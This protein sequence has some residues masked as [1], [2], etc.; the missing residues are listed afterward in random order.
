MTRHRIN[1]TLRVVYRSLG[2][3]LAIA[4]AAKLLTHVPGFAGTYWDDVAKDVYLYLKEMA[5]VFITVVA[6]YL[7]SVFGKR[8]NFVK[9]LEE[10]W[11]NIVRT[12]SALWSYFEKPYPT[13]DDYIATFARLSET[14]DTMRIVYR[15][16][17][18][19]RDLIGL[20]PYEPLHDMR[21]VLQAMDPRTKTSVTD[22]ERKRAQ[23]CLSQAFLA[24]RE[25]FLEELELHE[26]GH[27]LLVPGGRRMKVSGATPGGEKKR[28]R[29]QERHNKN[30]AP[31][32]EIDA[33]MGG[34]LAREKS[35][36]KPPP[37]PPDPKP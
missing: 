20:Y 11:R 7:T 12:K 32:P 23:E 10:E 26:P 13:T 22:A 19:T 4:L 37:K 27:P 3:V 33:Y 30:P 21:R 29:Q 15:N 34:L 9:S 2:A 35:A 31:N 8:A 16:V 24:L 6:V 28:A 14:I 25:N 18:E 17:G 5:P 1:R 36:G